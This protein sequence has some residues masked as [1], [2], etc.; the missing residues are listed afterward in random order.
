MWSMATSPQQLEHAIRFETLAYQIT[1]QPVELPFI[2][3]RL[4]AAKAL[5]QCRL[6]Q[7]VRIE[8]AEDLIHGL[9]R[10]GRPDAGAFYLPLDACSLRASRWRICF[11]DSSRRASR[12]SAAMYAGLELMRAPV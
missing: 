3:N 9:L 5:R 7:R 4:A 1:I 11:S 12:R 8:G 2:A 10:D 6:Q